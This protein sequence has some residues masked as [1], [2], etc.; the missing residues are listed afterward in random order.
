M[1]N[2]KPNTDFSSLRKM[3][4]SSEETLRIE[5]PW[6]TRNRTGQKF[7]VIKKC[8]VSHIKSLNV[9]Q[10]K[11]DRYVQ[12]SV[13]RLVMIPE[14]ISRLVAVETI[15]I[16]AFITELPMAISKLNNLKLLD[17]TGCY[18]L[19]SIPEE[20]LKMK[21]LKIKI[22][23]IISKA[24]EILFIPVPWTGI[25]PEVFS[26]IKSAN[27]KKIK[28]LI[29]RQTPYNQTEFEVPAEIKKFNELEMLSIAG[30]VSSLPSWIGNMNSLCSL[31]VSY[32]NLVS[33][34]SSIGN[35]SNLTSLN[36]SECH[37]LVSLPSSIGN[38]SNLT[39]LNLNGCWTLKSLP[40]TIG[41]LSN[42]T[43]LDLAGCQNLTSLPALLHSLSHLE[44]PL[45]LAGLLPIPSDMDWSEFKRE[46]N[47]V[48]Y[49]EYMVRMNKISSILSYL[50]EY[51]K[52]F[53]SE[54]YYFKGYE[55]PAVYGLIERKKKRGND[56]IGYLCLMLTN[57][58]KGKRERV[59]V[60]DIMEGRNDEKKRDGMKC[61]NILFMNIYGMEMK[62]ANQFWSNPVSTGR[63]MVEVWKDEGK[64]DS[65]G[66]KEWE[67][68]WR[69]VGDIMNEEDVM[70]TSVMHLC[71]PDYEKKKKEKDGVIV[72]SECSLNALS[73]LL[74]EISDWRCEYHFSVYD[75]NEQP[76]NVVIIRN[77]PSV[78]YL[79][80]DIGNQLKSM[81]QDISTTVSIYQ[82]YGV[83]RVTL[84][85]SDDA[86]MVAE[87]IDGCEFHG[88][89]LSVSVKGKK[90]EGKKEGEGGVEGM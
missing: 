4:Y 76:S 89:C 42:I 88:K 43:S 13:P 2:D 57:D 77:L 7:S 85:S 58:W 62:Q 16:N 79:N 68:K 19:L 78:F 63:R 55:I 70:E 10:D 6:Y 37:N 18:N 84:N 56:L 29:I 15:K 73:V 65:E 27:E 14:I 34:P 41:N 49:V 35:L 20:I 74:N 24:S 33:L 59:Y 71:I 31:T 28:Q 38:L 21:E 8:D 45:T 23:D 1:F 86:L 9:Q 81:I 67:K 26:K 75:I 48:S 87:R 12:Y 25:T 80:S 72:P 90:R 61:L 39:S 51:M 64:E 22:G 32:S 50:S 53:D 17:L 60:N 83:V 54:H 3:N 47:V 69:E 30:K 5:L 82:S 11:Y 52:R 36:L 46:M 66:R 40:E 44:T